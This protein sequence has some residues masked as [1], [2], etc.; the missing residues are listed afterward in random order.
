[1]PFGM[2]PYPLA[3]LLWFVVSSGAL[4]LCADWLWSYYD[5]LAKDRGL[6]WIIAAL[7]IPAAL[8][9]RNGQ[10]GILILLGLV[11]C[12]RFEKQDRPVT[13]GACLA[14]VSIKPQLLYLF[15][16]AALLLAYSRRRWRLL[17]STAM[18]VVALLAISLATNPS[19]V[20]EFVH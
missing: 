10:I 6:G 4:L 11:A 15:W 19:V 7:F 13:A 12:M 8:C 17:L 1:M 3:R 5:G 18:T 9:W 20:T 14:L 2:L 16:V